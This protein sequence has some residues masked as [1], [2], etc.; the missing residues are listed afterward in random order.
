MTDRCRRTAGLADVLMAEG[1]LTEDELMHVGACP[2]CARVVAEARAFE[3]ALAGVGAA[4]TPHPIEDPAAPLLAH[5]FHRPKEMSVRIRPSIGL[6]AALAGA[7]LAIVSLVILKPP[8]VDQPAPTGAS[9]SIAST[10]SPTGVPPQ[11]APAITVADAARTLGVPRDDVLLIPSGALAARREAQRVTL[12][13]VTGEGPVIPLTL[14]ALQS[15]SGE[16]RDSDTSGVVCAAGPFAGDAFVLAATRVQGTASLPGV[17]ARTLVSSAMVDGVRTLVAAL[18]ASSPRRFWALTLSHTAGGGTGYGGAFVSVPCDGSDPAA[19]LAAA[20]QAT[21]DDQSLAQRAVDEARGVVPATDALVGVEA[22]GDVPLVRFWTPDA[23]TGGRVV[24]GAEVS[25]LAPDGP[26]LA[27]MRAALDAPCRTLGTFQDYEGL[28]DTEPVRRVLAEEHGFQARELATACMGPT[29]LVVAGHTDALLPPTGSLQQE[30]VA[31]VRRSASGDW[32][33]ITVRSAEHM[34]GFAGIGGIRLGL[35]EGLDGAYAA[36]YGVPFTI[37]PVSLELESGG[38]AYRYPIGPEGFL[39]VVPAQ[40]A[41]SI[42]Y[43]YLARDG[44]VVESGVVPIN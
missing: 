13:G 25:L 41:E 16:G 8:G 10:T 34:D 26:D 12:V 42:T 15:G 40:P 14:V 5:E 37:D 18:D 31:V 17:A 20:A 36:V 2:A 7:G 1:D 44:R 32:D 3:R 4:V 21:A 19:A 22:C 30:Y 23:P 43:R 33:A 39:A 35:A 27:A 6:V 38:V 9:A 24:V 29:T 28:P 11:G